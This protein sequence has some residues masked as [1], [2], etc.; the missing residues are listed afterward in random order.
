MS[1]R[2]KITILSVFL[3]LL[4]LPAIYVALTWQ[5]AAPFTFRYLER[6]EPQKSLFTPSGSSPSTPLV[7]IFLEAQNT[8]SRPVHLGG[9]ELRAR[10]GGPRQLVYTMWGGPPIPPQ[11]TA[12]VQVLV[13]PAT[14]QRVTREDFEVS[15]RAFSKTKEKTKDIF[16]KLKSMA[17]SLLHRDADPF[18]SAKDEFVTPLIIDPAHQE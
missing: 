15:Y 10:S 6:G 1:P 7:P 3:L 18:T 13:D 11:G 5:V 4:G 16:Y 9:V 12:R 17:P 8:S 14:A 2:T